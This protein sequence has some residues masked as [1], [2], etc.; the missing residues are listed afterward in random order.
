M[1]PAGPRSS[2]LP[3]LARGLALRRLRRLAVVAG[4]VGVAASA[5]RGRRPAPPS[6]AGGWRELSGP[7]LR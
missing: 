7:E 2:R 5:A 4:L 3:A 1:R 6:S